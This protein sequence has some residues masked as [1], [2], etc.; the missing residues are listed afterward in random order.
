[1]LLAWQSTAASRLPPH[2]GSEGIDLCM[3]QVGETPE[4]AH[5]EWAEKGFQGL[6]PNPTVSSPHPTPPSAGLLGD[7][8]YL[9][10]KH[11]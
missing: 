10:P 4:A 11:S 8:A 5:V 1:M 9:D 2:W 3:E 7:S 6:C